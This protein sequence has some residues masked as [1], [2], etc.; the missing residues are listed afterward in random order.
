MATSR[1]ALG[2]LHV[3]VSLSQEQHFVPLPLTSDDLT[4]QK[5]LMRHTSR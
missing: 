2:E 1:A 3:S 4:F 5:V